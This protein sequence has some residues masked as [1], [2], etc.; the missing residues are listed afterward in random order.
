MSSYAVPQ[1]VEPPAADPG[2][3]YTVASGDLRLSA[4]VT[5]WPTQQKLEADFTAA[6]Q[7]LGWSVRR[8]HSFDPAKGHGFIDSQRA[9]IEV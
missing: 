2:V 6:V 5:C 7:D 8:A 9:G 3:L 4:N 1:L